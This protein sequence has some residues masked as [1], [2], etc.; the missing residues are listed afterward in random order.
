MLAGQWSHAGTKAGSKVYPARPPSLELLEPRLLLNADL[1]A[2]EP[3][4]PLEA[5]LNEQAIHANV[6]QDCDESQ[7]SDGS[8]L[9][10]Y[11]ASADGSSPADPIAPNQQDSVAGSDGFSIEP[12][13]PSVLLCDSLIASSM[14]TYAEKCRSGAPAVAGSACTPANSCVATSA[15]R[16]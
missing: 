9:L 13:G 11:L 3:L 15:C 12:R 8:L 4:I 2:G 1:L 10:T 7:E 14:T 16:R 5:S 6:S